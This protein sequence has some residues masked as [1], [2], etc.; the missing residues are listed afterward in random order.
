M[1]TNGMA[2]TNTTQPPARRLTRA[3]AK[4]QTREQLLGAAEVVFGRAGYH[5]ASLDQVA[6]EAGFTKGA[7]YSTFDS[8]ADLFLAVLA[9]RSER[10]RAEADTALVDAASVEEFCETL[11]RSFAE[12]VARE[13]DFWAALIEFMAL[14]S[15]D[16]ELSARFAVHHDAT[17]AAVAASI[18]EWSA[19]RRVPPP[20]EPRRAA[21]A[22][23]ALNNGLTIERLLS[24]EEVDVALY[25]EA[26]KALLL[27][28][29]NLERTEVEAQ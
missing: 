17:R 21:T 2:T 19:R 27:G 4:A 10:R 12:S 20:I 22:V 15:R 16:E 7:V 8:K 26:Q 3:E 11:A 23:I 9:R 28:A 13:P 18:E 14:V 6:A 29:W 1:N 5:S 25:V 24:A